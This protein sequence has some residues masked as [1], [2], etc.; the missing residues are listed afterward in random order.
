MGSKLST[1]AKN[2]VQKS[3]TTLTNASVRLS[4][5]PPV[6]PARPHSVPPSGFPTVPPEDAAAVASTKLAIDE[7]K[8]ELLAQAKAWG[9][10]TKKEQTKMPMSPLHISDVEAQSAAATRYYRELAAIAVSVHT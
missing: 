7:I 1:A 10:L 6:V 3:P 2:V 5:N 9:P 4:P 8:P